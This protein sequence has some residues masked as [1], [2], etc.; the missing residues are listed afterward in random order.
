[1]VTQARPSILCTKCHSTVPWAAHCPH[2]WAYLEFA[3]NPPWRPEGLDGGS[4]GETE[5]VQSQEG[6]APED[7]VAASG[8]AEIL[9]EG[10]SDAVA[11]SPSLNPTDPGADVQSPDAR[12]VE[13]GGRSSSESS[14]A[15]IVEEPPIVRTTRFNIRQIIAA[16][17]VTVL[18]IALMI[19]VTA[20]TGWWFP[21]LLGPVLLVALLA[22]A[23][24]AFLEIPV[25]SPLPVASDEEF[26]EFYEEEEDFDPSAYTPQELQARR[27]MLN[28]KVVERTTTGDAACAACERPNPSSNHFCDWCGAVM[29]GVQLAPATK[30][31]VESAEEGK[32]KKKRRGPTRTWRSTGPA[33]LIAAAVVGA[34]AFAFF[35]PGALQSRLSLTRVMQGASQWVN[36]MVGRAATVQ[37]VTGSASLPGTTP[38]SLD[39]N[40][41]NTFW[42]SAISPAMGENSVLEFT[43]DRPTEIDRMVIL[44][45]IQNKIFGSE[46]V[47]YPRTIA[48]T[49][50]D[51]SQIEGSLQ[52]IQS[53]E[54]LKQMIRFPARTTKSVQ[55]KVTA[56]YLPLGYKSGDY[57]AVAISGVE[58]LEPPQPPSAFGVQDR[59]LRTPALPGAPRPN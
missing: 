5:E 14:T 50:D 7:G 34:L 23:Y 59:G 43:F 15:E 30:V 2:C 40:D 33:F 25:A 41:A 53:D 58:F 54:D 31:I 11:G 28:Q 21:V 55:M 47:A 48:L 29:P 18:T 26:E 35:G 10:S 22:A 38:S 12:S 19:A 42:A 24:L 56:V 1:M 57:G 32:K 36:P 37:S 6:Q 3:G 4:D 20:Q 8:D 39:A 52:P 44:P 13:G 27:A 46:S 49:F 45:G 17:V 16:V 9:H 51:G